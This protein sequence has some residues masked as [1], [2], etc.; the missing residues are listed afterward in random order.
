VIIEIRN[1]RVTKKV[2]RTGFIAKEAGVRTRQA[3]IVIAVLLTGIIVSLVVAYSCGVLADDF[4]IETR[5]ITG[6]Y[7]VTFQSHCKDR[8]PTFGCAE[9]VKMTVLKDGQ[10][11]FSKE[12]FFG[13]GPFGI[14]FKGAYPV[15]EWPDKN[16]LR[17][18]SSLSEQPVLDTIELWNRTGENLDVVEVFYGRY[19]R[20][21]IFD[22]APEAK[23]DLVA[24]PQFTTNLP[25]ASTVIYKATNLTRR[26]ELVRMVEGKKR[27]S[28]SEGPLKILV[29]IIDN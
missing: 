21:V 4:I 18:G 10:L 6:T 27:A 14:H 5:S 25:P 13:E 8:R 12:P 20:F 22:F 23:I 29:E 16:I 17:L 2:K 26:R 3:I 19:E 15:I 9:I 11:F 28:K 7:Q 1:E 24:S